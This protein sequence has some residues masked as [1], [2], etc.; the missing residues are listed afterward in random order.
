MFVLA[1]KHEKEM[2]MRENVPI[3]EAC[4]DFFQN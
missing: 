1:A 2:G 3:S 4:F